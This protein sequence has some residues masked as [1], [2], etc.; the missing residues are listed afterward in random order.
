MG[1]GS[2]EGRSCHRNLPCPCFSIAW[3]PSASLKPKQS[4]CSSQPAYFPATA[5]TT[6]TAPTCS[7]NTNPQ[8]VLRNHQHGLKCQ[9]RPVR[10]V[11]SLE[12]TWPM[13][14][15]WP[16]IA[17]QTMDFCMTFGCHIGHQHPHR[18]QLQE[19][20][21]FTCSSQRQLELG[22]YNGLRWQHR[23]LT[24]IGPS[25]APWS[26]DI[27]ITTT[28]TKDI[29]H[30]QGKGQVPPESNFKIFVLFSN[31]WIICISF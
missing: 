2:S 18:F 26:M 29:N 9:C 15:M 28:Q 17:A 10:S 8:K 1:R 14:P 3:M 25:M 22:H 20:H 31:S 27:N 5:Q 13:E 12:A 23:P 21:G 4:P 30:R 11:G 6:N 19:D 16:Q 24:S 7:R